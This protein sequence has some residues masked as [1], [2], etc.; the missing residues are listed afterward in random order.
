MWAGVGSGNIYSLIL[1]SLRVN[2]FCRLN[3]SAIK[4]GPITQ[5]RVIFQPQRVRNDAVVR[6]DEDL[7]LISFITL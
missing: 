4:I 7:T 2:H 6:P 3:S 1:I 5:P